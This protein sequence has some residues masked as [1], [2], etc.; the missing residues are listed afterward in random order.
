MRWPEFLHSSN[1]KDNKCRQNSGVTADKKD[2]L[3]ANV[4]VCEKL[5]TFCM[6]QV[7]LNMTHIR[8]SCKSVMRHQKKKKKMSHRINC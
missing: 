8:N 7:R 2:C 3:T 1:F 6:F 4:N 5:F